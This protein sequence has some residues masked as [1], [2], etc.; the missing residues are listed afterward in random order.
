MLRR[1]R[2]SLLLLW[3]QRD[4][5]LWLELWIT[6]V[7]AGSWIIF[8]IG[9]LAQTNEYHRGK[10]EFWHFEI[11]WHFG[12]LAEYIDIRANKFGHNGE[13]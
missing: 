6:G 9:Q 4:V 1:M 3:L 8:D 11:D 12:K 5:K 2:D 7:I 10:M 13:Q